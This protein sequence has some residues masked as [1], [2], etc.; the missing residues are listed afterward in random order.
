MNIEHNHTKSIYTSQ[1]TIT[2]WLV[3]TFITKLSYTNLEKTK[4]DMY[5]FN[6]LLEVWFIEIDI[7]IVTRFSKSD[8]RTIIYII[9]FVLSLG[10]VMRYFLIYNEYI[11]RYSSIYK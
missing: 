9:H 3:Y 1:R 10:S 4:N 8:H 11:Y 6:L 7:I 2:L 5:I